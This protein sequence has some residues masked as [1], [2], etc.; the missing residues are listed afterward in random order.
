MRRTAVFALMTALVLLLSA[1]GEK[2][3]SEKFQQFRDTLP[4]KTVQA[5]ADVFGEDGGNRLEY[6][7]T[8]TAKEGVSEVE[9]LAPADIYGV[10]ARISENGSSVEY[11]GVVLAVGEETARSV[12]P[13]SALPAVIESLEKGW[14][15]NTWREELEGV[16]CLAA[17]F[18]RDEDVTVTVWMNYSTMIP[19]Y[20]EISTEN[21]VYISCVIS[22]WRVE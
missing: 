10:K 4:G 3:D 11:E 19:V 9:V 21:Q 18:V 13:V 22:E 8:C 20:A 17:A 2:D 7:L 5:T 15:K 1:C 6:K 12:S 16:P 14:V